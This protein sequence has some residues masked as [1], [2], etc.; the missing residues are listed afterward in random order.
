MPGQLGRRGRVVVAVGL[1]PSW[2]ATPD[3]APMTP[4]SSMAARP[5]FG[6]QSSTVRRLVEAKWTRWCIHTGTAVAR[7]RAR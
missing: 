5:R 1:L 4:G 7:R 2:M 3:M 6:W